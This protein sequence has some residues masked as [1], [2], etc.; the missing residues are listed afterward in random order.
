MFLSPLSEA[1]KRFENDGADFET[2]FAIVARIYDADPQQPLAWSQLRPRLHSG[3][4]FAAYV[5]F[6]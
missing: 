2:G 1:G 3:L 5:R 6:R 4:C